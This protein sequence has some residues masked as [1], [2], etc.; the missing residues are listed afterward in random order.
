M[1]FRACEK[2]KPR[3]FN[4]L[5]SESLSFPNASIS[6]PHGV[7]TGP[8]IKTFGGDSDGMI[9]Q[10]RFTILLDLAAAVQASLLRDGERRE[11]VL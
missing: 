11:N 8:P 6:D 7:G 4:L 9:Y 2:D 3:K 10:N 1:R 5:T